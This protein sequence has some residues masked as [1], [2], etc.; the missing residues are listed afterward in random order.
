MK[1]INLYKEV[2]NLFGTEENKGLSS[3]K[4]FAKWNR[5]KVNI[6]LI[7]AWLIDLRHET[8]QHTEHT[9]ISSAS[10]LI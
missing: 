2:A 10:V 3:E 8:L 5:S 6:L 4:L 1:K 9:T 7:Q